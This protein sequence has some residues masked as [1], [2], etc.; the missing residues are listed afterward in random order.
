MFTLYV[1][2]VSGGVVLLLLLAKIWESKRRKS[3]L[4]LRIISSGDEK[5]KNLSHDATLAYSVLKEKGEFFINKQLPLHTKNIL[6]KS[7]T[8]IKE[9]GEKYLGNIRNSKLLRPKNEG[10]SEFF[11]N[12][13]EMEKENSEK[14]EENEVDKEEKARPLET[15]KKKI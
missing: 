10:I 3:F 1:F 15:P 8:F 7:E 12:M 4:M 14:M 9:K 13:S 2:Y 5:F 11:K 6:N